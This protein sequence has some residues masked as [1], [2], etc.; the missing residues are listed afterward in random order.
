MGP[1]W[2]ALPPLF[3]CLIHPDTRRGPIAPCGTRNLFSSIR[4]PLWSN[5]PTPF[6]LYKT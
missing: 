2:F 5:L 3:R 6:L 1:E 4:S